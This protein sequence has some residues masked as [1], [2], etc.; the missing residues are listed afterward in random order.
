VRTITALVS[1]LLSSLYMADPL[2]PPNA[3]SG[4]TVIAELQLAE[5]KVTKVDI[6][7]GSEPFAGSCV[8]ALAKWRL[9]PEFSGSELAVVHFRQ[10]YVQGLMPTEEDVS[11]SNPPKRLPYPRYLVHPFY[12]PNALARGSVILR[13]EITADGRVSNIETIKG[14]GALTGTS[15]EALKR[16]QFVPAQDDQGASILSHAYVV[17]VFRFPLMAP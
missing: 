5:G 17:F 6:L 12:P 7:S 3:V 11:L 15:I 2:F 14:M 13:A 8:S 9:Q 4:G 10:P 16:W 1:F